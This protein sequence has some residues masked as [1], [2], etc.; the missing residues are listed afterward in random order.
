MVVQSQLRSTVHHL[1]SGGAAAFVAFV[2]RL[3]CL[4][5]LCGGSG[6][7]SSSPRETFDDLLPAF[8]ARSKGVRGQRSVGI[9]PILTL[10]A[11]TCILQQQ[12]K[13]RLPVLGPI[14]S[15][16]GGASRKS[17]DR[18]RGRKSLPQPAPSDRGGLEVGDPGTAAAGSS[19]VIPVGGGTKGLMPWL[20]HRIP[21]E[22]EQSEHSFS[23]FERTT[24]TG[25][26]LSSAKNYRCSA[27]FAVDRNRY[28]STTRDISRLDLLA[29]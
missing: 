5:P 28:V 24:G 25:S 23:W 19:A 4:F 27:T 17:T 22:E 16:Q 15:T 20:V 14:Q 6:F 7:P 2:L 18:S 8:E 3:F 11:N 12:Q 21:E 13:R 10:A 9:R 1:S 26:L 29:W